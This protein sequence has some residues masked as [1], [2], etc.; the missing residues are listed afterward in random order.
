VRFSGGKPV[1]SKGPFVATRE[2]VGGYYVVDAKD[3]DDAIAL[4]GRI[5]MLFEGMAVEVRAIAGTPD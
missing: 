1:V 2:H 4:A 3:L 5:P